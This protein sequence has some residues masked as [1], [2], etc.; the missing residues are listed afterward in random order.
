MWTAHMWLSRSVVGCRRV[1]EVA[2]TTTVVEDEV[3]TCS[4]WLAIVLLAWTNLCITNCGQMVPD[5]TMVCN[6]IDSLWKHTIA[7]LNSTVVG[8]LLVPLPQK[9]VV[10][11]MSISD[12]VG[13]A[14]LLV[15]ILF[16][17]TFGLLLC[18]YAVARYQWFCVYYTYVT[19][20]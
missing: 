8:P 14:Y 9:V 10:K 1:V 16:R 15:F 19:K 3:N 2:V 11:K 4:L 20:Q 13:L 7:L 5:T 6:C 12:I 17:E 18:W